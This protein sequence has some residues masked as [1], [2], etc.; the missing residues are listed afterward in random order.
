MIKILMNV[1]AKPG[2]QEVIFTREF[3][4]PRNLVFKA[5][6]DQELYKQWIGPEGINIT[7]ES[8]ESI[9]GGSWRYIQHDKRG[10][11]LAFHGVYHEVTSPERIITTF[12]FEGLPEKGHVILQKRIFEALPNNR[13]KLS[14]QFIFLSVEERDGMLPT[15]DDHIY[16]RLDLL[17]KKFKSKNEDK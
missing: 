4:A 2:K 9:S 7:F 1:I 17:L 8:F 13:T 5:F 6:T 16:D 11:E 3:D 12:E 10:N 15:I 14:T